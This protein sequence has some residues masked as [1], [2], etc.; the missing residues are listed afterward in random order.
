MQTMDIDDD[1]SPNKPSVTFSGI[2]SNTSTQ[3]LFLNILDD[4]SILSTPE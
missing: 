3:L 2:N 4:I 1:T